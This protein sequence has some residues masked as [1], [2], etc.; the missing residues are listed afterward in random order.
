MVAVRCE[1]LQ[2][3]RNGDLALDDISVS[4][5]Q[6]TLTIVFGP[7]GGGK[8]TFLKI[9]AGLMSPS[10]GDIAIFGAR[11]KESIQDIGYVPQLA[12][13]ERRFPITVS[14]AVMMG[15]YGRIGMFHSAKASDHKAVQT[16]LAQVELEDKSDRF[17]RTLSGG[18]LQR[19][20]IARA[21]VRDPKL[22]LLDEVSSGVDVG[23]KL[24]LLSLLSE[25]KSKMTIIFVTHDMS[26]V[27]KNVDLVMCLNK[28][29]VTHGRPEDALTD[30]VLRC[31]YG[32]DATLFSHCTAP[33]AHVHGHE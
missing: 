30:Q 31:M 12:R 29:L 1:K 4:I 23:V 19:M 11:V 20:L 22:L 33:H 32:N 13:F 24:S 28:K 15:R 26:V 27:S 3:V 6:N 21:L 25:L 5:P 16:V 2:V 7:N 14:E 18:E 8:T 10:G 17:V 9:L